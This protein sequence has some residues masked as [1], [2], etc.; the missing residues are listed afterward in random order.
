MNILQTK[1]I[2]V[3]KRTGVLNNKAM[4][5]LNYSGKE[6]HGDEGNHMFKSFIPDGVDAND[7]DSDGWIELDISNED[8]FNCL[9]SVVIPPPPTTVCEFDDEGMEDTNMPMNICN[10]N[11]GTVDKIEEMEGDEKEW[12]VFMITQDERNETPNADPTR[13]I[14]ASVPANYDAFIPDDED[15]ESSLESIHK[16][17]EEED[18]I[19]TPT[20]VPPSELDK[21]LGESVSR[22]AMSMKRSEMSRQKVLENIPVGSFNHFLCRI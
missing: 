2:E 4:S 16:S 13:T 19:M 17:T 1:F 9:T 14:G 7:G 8:N 3:N 10:G 21:L 5:T 20:M 22:L 11:D 6:D 18:T 12:S 15:H